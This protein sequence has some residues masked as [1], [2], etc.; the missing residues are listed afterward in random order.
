[1]MDCL[2]STWEALDSTPRSVKKL[3]SERKMQDKAVTELLRSPDLGPISPQLYLIRS[4]ILSPVGAI[5]EV[6]AELTLTC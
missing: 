5:A 3:L 1:M 6:H 4:M 2:P